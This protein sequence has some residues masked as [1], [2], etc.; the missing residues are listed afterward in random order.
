MHNKTV[1][2]F[3]KYGSTQVEETLNEVKRQLESYGATVLLGDTTATEISGERVLGNRGYQA[4]DYAIVVGGDGTLLHAARTLATYQTPIIGINLGQLGFLTDIPAGEIQTGLAAIRD[5]HYQIEHRAMLE[6]AII[7]NDENIFVGISLN[8]VVISKGDTGRLLEMRIE[9]DGQFVSK[10]RS[11]GLIFSTPTGSTA[12]ALSAGGPIISPTLPVWVMV[13]ICPHTL[14][15]RPIILGKESQIMISEMTLQ[16]NTANLALDGIIHGVIQ[17]DDRV[18]I[19]TAKETLPL[20][21]IQTHNHFEALRS[22]LG[23][24]S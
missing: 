1:G 24:S 4:L 6:T 23:W 3:G 13:P 10:T 19:N 22:K 17:P 16:D 14:S 11:D 2:L 21:R 8:D 5:G 20:I 7:R 12:Y 15:N 9:V 18:I